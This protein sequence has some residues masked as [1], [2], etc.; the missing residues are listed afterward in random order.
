[1]SDAP[2]L[3]S[4]YLGQLRKELLVQGLPSAKIDEVTSETGSHL[5]EML[6]GASPAESAASLKQFGDAR[7]LAKGIAAEYERSNRSKRYYWPAVFSLGASLLLQSPV[8]NTLAL[9]WI[10]VC[11]LL[12]AIVLGIMGFRA[13]KPLFG[14]FVALGIGVLVVW[15]LWAAATSYPVAYFDGKSGPKP[16]PV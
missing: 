11:I 9:P 13:R 1:M 7:A 10:D 15:T 8:I 2:D 5:G 12:S 3:I 6:E 14:Q 16:R 4:A